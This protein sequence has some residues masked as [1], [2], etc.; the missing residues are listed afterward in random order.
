MSLKRK[1]IIFVSGVALAAWISAAMTPG[2]PPATS[3]SIRPSPIDTKGAVLA[4]EIARLRERLRPD[5]TPR[6]AARNP[7]VFRS[8]QRAAPAPR[9]GATVDRNISAAAPGVDI[10]EPPPL[11]LTLAGIAED[12]GPAGGVPVRTA[13]IAGNGQLFLVKEGDTV[14]D[15]DIEYRVGNISAD[16]AELID[17]RDNT[18]RRLALR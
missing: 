18:T 10:V 5:A 9:V 4:G 3:I 11:R 13:I 12:P 16:S 15:R 7:F 1:T 14:T 17:L 2:R 8:S 6:E